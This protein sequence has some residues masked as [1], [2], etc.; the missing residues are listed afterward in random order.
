VNKPPERI[1]LSRTDSIGDVML[2]LP[3]AGLLKRRF[4]GVRIAFLGRNYTA[5]VLHCCSHIDEVITLDDLNNVDP[6]GSIQ[7]LATSK[8][9][10][11]VHVFPERDVARWCKSAG[12]PQR[13]GTSHRWWHWLTCTERVS[14]SRRK[15]D[16]HE[17][18]LNVKLLAPF[19]IVDTPS[20]DDLARLTGFQPS[21]ADEGVHALLRPGR[22]NV[23]LH[24]L[25][26]GSAVEWGLDRF[27]ELIH[28]LDPHRFHVIVTGTAAEAEQYRKG[29]PLRSAH[30]TDA[31]GRLSLDRLIALIGASDALVAASTGPLHIAAACGKRAIGLYASKRPIHPGRWAPIGSDVHALT[32]EG[33]RTGSDPVKQ[34]RAIAPERV[35]RLLEQLP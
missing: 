34:I 26:K 20:L 7:V 24:P 13:I 29:L 19:G 27:T 6:N 1:L 2:T 22:R 32:A 5:P 9:D 17:A 16:L 4:P 33:T 31:G 10:A 25:S 11:V 21:K 30:V 15:S 23:I 28:A 18:Q 35:V 14:F 3:M 12:I 8:S